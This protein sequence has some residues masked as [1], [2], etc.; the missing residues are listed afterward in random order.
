MRSSLLSPKFFNVVNKVLA[1]MVSKET[2]N[3]Q[4]RISIIQF[5]NRIMKLNREFVPLILNEVNLE[6]FLSLNLLSQDA[7]FT[8]GIA[9][10]FLQNF[11]RDPQFCH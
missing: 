3:S 10:E 5:L 8:S 2:Y 4:L 9:V 7:A 6:S 11:Q 1:Q